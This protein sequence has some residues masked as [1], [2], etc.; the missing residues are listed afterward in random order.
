MKQKS[1]TVNYPDIS[2]FSKNLKF[3]I[4]IKQTK[5]FKTNPVPGKILMGF[6]KSTC[7]KHVLG[8][9]TSIYDE[10]NFFFQNEIIQ[11]F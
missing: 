8:W 1:L 6:Q 2:V 9:K 7:S 5:G 11:V 3:I 10:F 4:E